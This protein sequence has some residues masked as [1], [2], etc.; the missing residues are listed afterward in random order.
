MRSASWRRLWP[1]WLIVALAFGLRLI[2]LESVPFG[3]H[4][5]EATKALLARDVLDGAGFPA[6]FSAFTGRDA[7][8]IYLEALFFAALG[9]SI[10]AARLLSA[11]I[12][13]LTVALTVA[14]MRPLVG[15]RVALLVAAFT[16]ISLWH[17][18][19]S[20][21]GYRAVSQPLVQLFALFFLVQ[22]DAA[23]DD[24]DRPFLWAGAAT[25]LTQYTYTAARVFPFIALGLA[26]LVFYR[27]R[28]PWRVAL[29]R[30]LL[31][32]A[33]F[34]VVCAPLAWHFARN[35]IDLYG[36][37]ARVSVFN[38]AFQ[39]GSGL[40]GGRLGR[41]LLETA[42]MFTVWGDISHRFNIPGRPVF[43]AW[44]QWLFWL[45]LPLFAWRL[46]RGPWRE[47]LVWLW[48]LAWIGVLLLPMTLTGDTLPYYQRAIG[49]LPAL[50]V[51]PALP[52]AELV[53]AAGRRPGLARWA[54]VAVA[55]L[56]VSLTAETA[57]AY[58]VTWHTA[59]ANDDDRRVAMVYVA[60][61]LRAEADDAS[62]Y[63]ST[64][65]FQH[66]TLA[67]LAPEQ[68]DRVHWFNLRQTLAL[69]PVG[70]DAV[71]IVM[72]ETG[73]DQ[74]LLDRAGFGAPAFTGR[75]R[76]GRDVFDVYRRVGAVPSADRTDG[77]FISPEVRFD[78]P[79]LRQPVPFPIRFGDDLT[80]LGYARPADTVRPG[81]VVP[82]QLFWALGS[83]PAN[84]YTIFTHI[85]SPDGQLVAGH[86]AND[87]PTSFWRTDGGEFMISQ[88]YL[89]LP[90]DL[91]AGTYP[92]EIGLY[93]PGSGTRLPLRID[94]MDAA[95]RLLLPN[96]T[97]A[98]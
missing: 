91:P 24:R 90:G 68:Y 52:L 29:R 53:R 33:A 26:L 18:I 19:A 14:V 47:R 41:S 60:E 80:L 83:R 15:R 34:A 5:D 85:L 31:F 1:A 63:L 87:Y 4:P 11:L 50:F 61:A 43:G 9:E 45:G 55:L 20:R 6:F 88:F 79:E 7:L 27:R 66:P 54:W 12:G 49:I 23:D 82:L 98:P 70:E 57:R 16:A 67:L 8:Y 69:P 39:G 81:D 35:P 76:F 77:A 51:I 75:D 71:Y 38:D 48:L 89:A 2:A 86:D 62:I 17:L 84:H 3:W 42:R 65:L 32:G 30:L 37:A 93:T 44:D 96:L 36:R 94:D 64:D 78:R 21:N 58:F 97:I 25:G 59:T 74:A 13:G 28:T 46:G 22:A 92:F 56:L 95:D 40:L 10:F 72:R 73:A